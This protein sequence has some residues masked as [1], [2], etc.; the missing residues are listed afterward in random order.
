MTILALLLNATARES[1]SASATT[2]RWY[3]R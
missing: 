3:A 2:H 1:V